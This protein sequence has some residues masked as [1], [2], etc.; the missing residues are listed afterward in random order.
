MGQKS[1]V[2]ADLK[3][4]RL[5]LILTGSLT[6]AHLQEIYTDIRF[7]VAD[8]KPG[9][10]VITDLR[11]CK[12]GH[13]AGLGTFTRIREYLAQNRVGTVVRIAHKNQLIFHQISKII[14]KK[15]NYPIIYVAS[16]EEADAALEEAAENQMARVGNAE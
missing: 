11:Q 7:C 1:K 3:R 8:L 14:C 12:I 16:P 13:L 10:H 6:L 4:N 15:S 2:R 5:E 9:F